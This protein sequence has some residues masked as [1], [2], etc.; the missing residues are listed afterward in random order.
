M[1]WGAAVAER[2]AVDDVFDLISRTMYSA[3]LGGAEVWAKLD[4]T[5]P[6]LKVL[7]L[8]GLHG[9]APVSWL[10]S[11]MVVSP[12]NV[13]GILDRLEHND[14]VRRTNDAHDR[15]VV[16]V[17]LTEKG[18]HLLQDLQ[19]AGNERVRT[20][21]ADMRPADRTALRQGLAALLDKAEAP[22][23]TAAAPRRSARRAEN[24]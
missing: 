11:R 6:Q 23:P 17:V 3:L 2:D 7:M 13:T 18:E 14:W 8:L 15:R 5:M 10:A 16:R 20:S 4:I 22:P 21:L 1:E 24:A 19:A 12:P 9:S